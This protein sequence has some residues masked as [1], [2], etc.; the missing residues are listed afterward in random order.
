MA[1]LKAVATA[2]ALFAAT[3]TQVHA[4]FCDPAAF[5]AQYPNRDVL[6]GGALTQEGAAV[7]GLA[8]PRGVYAGP[9]DTYNSNRQPRP[10]RTR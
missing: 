1:Q 9:A 5:Q 6:N 7:A 8:N 2:L 10:R 3:I 4:Q